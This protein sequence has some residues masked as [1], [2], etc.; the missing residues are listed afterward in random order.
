[1]SDQKIDW[2][3]IA[4]DPKFIQLSRKKNLFLLTAMCFSICFYFL[5]PIGAAY[6]PNIF[7]IQIYGPFNIGIAFALLQ[8]VV[9]WSVAF[10]YIKKANAEFDPLAEEIKKSYATKTTQQK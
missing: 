2:A 6:L 7:K 3:M 9:A 5:L 8:F 10:I 4:K 1:M